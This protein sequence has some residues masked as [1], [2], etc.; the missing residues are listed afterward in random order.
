MHVGCD[1]TLVDSGR[2]DEK[3]FTGVARCEGWSLIRSR[4]FRFVPLVVR[5]GGRSVHLADIELFAVGQT[6]KLAVLQAT[7]VGGSN[8]PG[9][10]ASKAGTRLAGAKRMAHRGVGWRDA[11]RSPQ[12]GFFSLWLAV[13]LDCLSSFWLV[14]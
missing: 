8:P 5:D 2:R 6:A 9:F 12:E 10:T 14:C 1:L 3:M 7:N 13:F 4:Y 11:S